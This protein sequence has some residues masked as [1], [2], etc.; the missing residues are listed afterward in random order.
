MAIISCWLWGG[1]PER[2]AAGVVLWIHFVFGVITWVVGDVYVDSMIEDFILT[3]AFGWLVFRSDRWWPFVVTATCVL[4]LLVHVLTMVTNIS[5]GAAV[6]A[7]VGLG[8]MFNVA[9]IAGV[10]ERRLAGEQAV[11]D[12]LR[13]RRRKAA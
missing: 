5:W 9:L 2:Y 3:L 8:L 1:R 6:S 7:R 13:W 4:S 11:S 10:F 12:R